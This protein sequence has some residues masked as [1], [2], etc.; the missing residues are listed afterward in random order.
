M[1]ELTLLQ[2]DRQVLRFLVV[3]AGRRPSET[4]HLRF[5]Q[6]AFVRSKQRTVAILINAR[7]T[8]WFVFLPATSIRPFS[9]SRTSAA[10]R[11][12]TQKIELVPERLHTFH[13]LLQQGV[14]LAVG[15]IIGS[16]SL[17]YNMPK[18]TRWKK[19]FGCVSGPCPR[20]PTYAVRTTVVL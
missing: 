7:I 4:S 5:E 19:Q 17:R 15:K 13:E 20:V 16:S 6:E 11:H 2:E 12:I 10:A 18:G 8:N 14:A 1:S 3:L 9:Q